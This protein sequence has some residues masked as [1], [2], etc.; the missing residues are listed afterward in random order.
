MIEFLMHYDSLINT[1]KKSFDIQGKIRHFKFLIQTVAGPCDHAIYYV[2]LRPLAC[3]NCA[4]ES[5]HGHRCTSLV[6]VV[7]C[8]DCGTLLCVIKKLRE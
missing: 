3:W 2:G 5:H 7:C 8:Q 1:I 4:F 6:I